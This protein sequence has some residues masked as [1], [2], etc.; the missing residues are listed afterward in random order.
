MDQVPLHLVYQS[1]DTFEVQGTK[2]VAIRGMSGAEDG[3]KRFCTLCLTL[4]MEVP[5]GCEPML[6]IIIF[7][8][9]GKAQRGE[10]THYHDKV[11]VQWQEKA[12]TDDRIA[13]DYVRLLEQHVKAQEE[14]ISARVTTL[15]AVATAEGMEPPLLA[16]LPP[17]VK[18][19][20][21]LSV[22]GLAA[23][24]TEEFVAKLRSIRFNRF[25]LPG[26]ETECTQP[27]D[28][29][30]AALMHWLV[31]EEQS[32]WIEEDDNL[33]LW[34]GNDP[35]RKMTM[36]MK[37]ILMTHWVGAAHIEMNTNPK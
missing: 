35:N 4:Q 33:V 15:A 23:H 13:V 10:F 22:D 20:R 29:G 27:V 9:K 14:V 17:A 24:K 30:Q 21:V 12:W 11:L 5:E 18:E 6:P 1:K 7:R 19:E 8:G 36:S 37:R 16:L 26:G 34:E 32:K 31:E 28:K 25:V 2:T 3:E